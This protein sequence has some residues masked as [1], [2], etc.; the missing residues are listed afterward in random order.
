MK[1]GL[2]GVFGGLLLWLV[3]VCR[4][5][6]QHAEELYQIQS[7]GSALPRSL[8]CAGLWLYDQKNRITG[9]AGKRFHNGAELRTTLFDKYQAAYIGKWS[10]EEY[11]LSQVKRLSQ[12]WLVLI[13]ACGAGL[14]LAVCT[15]NPLYSIDGKQSLPRPREWEDTATWHLVVEEAGEKEELEISVP[16][17]AETGIV[18]ILETEANALPEQILGEN[19]SLDAVMSNLELPEELEGGVLV[20]WDSSLPEVVSKSGKVHNQELDE[21]GTIAELTAT[22]SYGEESLAIVIPV[23]V[24]PPA[25]DSTYYL[26]RLE[27]LIAE[28][29][30]ENRNAYYVY[31]PDEVEGHGVSYSNKTD[32]RPL[33]LF[34]AG[35]IVAVCIAFLYRQ[36][37]EEAYQERNDQLQAEYS[38][39]VSEL[40]ILLHC[41]LPVRA[42]W[43]RMV[44]AYEQERSKDSSRF[45]YVLEEMLLTYRQMAGGVPEAGAYLTFGNRCGLYEYRRLGML[46]EQTVRQGSRGLMALLENEAVWAME[47]RKN[48]ARKRGEEAGTKMMLPMF[49]MFGVVVAVVMIPALMSF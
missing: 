22:L 37:V 21:E 18:S 17:W 13:A 40:A 9:L 19:L 24:F 25:K 44:S 10:R 7:K 26:S 2:A 38:K 31:L 32:N 36:Q 1:Y 27:E 23:Q 43:H 34:F 35:V 49:M 29:V 3:L 30:Q 15:Q 48:L 16:G 28:Q 11:E 12:A 8:L 5:R 41:G 4:Y 46:L 20:T 42:C 39:L 6:V 14:L 45:S 33:Y 47:Q